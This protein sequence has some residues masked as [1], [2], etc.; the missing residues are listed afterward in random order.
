[1]DTVDAETRARMMSSVSHKDTRPEKMLR[2][3]LHQA[4]L[5]F[6]LHA[7]ELP[8]TPD[9]SLPKFGAVAF[10]NGCY[11]H[12]HGCYKSTTPQSNRDFWEKK[13]RANKA[14]D[15][16][17]RLE[18]HKLGW[19]IL[20]VWECSLLGKNALQLGEIVVMVHTWLEETQTELEVSGDVQH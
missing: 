3:A 8:G 6:R 14:R 7:R 11:W 4:G 1:M 16:R 20:T 12:S 9:I 5:R 2:S 15:R 19:R 17:N 18:L 10:V 13:F